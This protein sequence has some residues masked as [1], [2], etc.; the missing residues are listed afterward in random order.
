MLDSGA[1]VSSLR[2]LS[3]VVRSASR[4]HEPLIAYFSG[5][6]YLAPSTSSLQTTGINCQGAIRD[7]SQQQR[8][9]SFSCVDNLVNK[10]GPRALPLATVHMLYR[11]TS[12]MTIPFF[13]YFV[14]IDR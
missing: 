4:V 8:Y 10:H 5:M 11:S 7:E 1:P 14:S 6:S 13:T 3:G 9:V 2:I 12:S